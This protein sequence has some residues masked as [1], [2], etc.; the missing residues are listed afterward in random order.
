[1]CTGFEY[2]HVLKKSNS[3]VP[4]ENCHIRMETR[5]TSMFRVLSKRAIACTERVVS[6][7]SGDGR[8]VHLQGMLRFQRFM[9]RYFEIFLSTSKTFIAKVTSAGYVCSYLRLW[10]M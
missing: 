3:T 10:R 7:E 4:L 8:G 9:R 6:N 1:M 5:T 2:W